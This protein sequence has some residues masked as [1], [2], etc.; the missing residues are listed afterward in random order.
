M[1]YCAGGVV[2]AHST[3]SCCNK[4][5]PPLSALSA[6]LLVRN[7]PP[8]SY[9]GPQASPSRADPA[10]HHPCCA[11]IA[12]GGGLPPHPL[13]KS[14]WASSVAVAAHTAWLLALLLSAHAPSNSTAG[15][16]W[17]KF[18]GSSTGKL[19]LL[20]KALWTNP[21]SSTNVPK[22]LS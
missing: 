16:F 21:S 9:A 19:P 12:G 10:P 7:T 11:P 17:Y 5:A 8:S 15:E 1:D 4:R 3:E 6:Q 22:N 13:L 18:V 14:N 20:K 2:Q